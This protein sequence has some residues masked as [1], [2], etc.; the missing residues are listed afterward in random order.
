[1]IASIDGEELGVG[2]RQATAIINANV[3]MEVYLTRVAARWGL[4]AEDFRAEAASL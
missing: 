3:K 4:F 2:S 1:M